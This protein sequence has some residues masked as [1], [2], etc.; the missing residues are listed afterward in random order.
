[1]SRSTRMF[2]IIQFLRAAGKPLTGREIAER[3]EVT[4]RT[5]YRDIA[6]LQAM[7]VPIVGEAGRRLCDARGLRSAAPDAD[8]R[9]GRGD[10]GR[11]G[12]VW[13]G[14]ATRVCARRR[15]ARGA[16]SARPCPADRKG[17]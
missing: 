10:R 8:R 6:A 2:E 16:R 12:A 14:L 9:R 3:L 13:T 1:M 11:L 17:I 15:P 7:R 5:V 4:K